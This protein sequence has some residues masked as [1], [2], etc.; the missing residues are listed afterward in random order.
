MSVG[1]VIITHGDTGRTLVEAGEFILGQSLDSIRTV[2]FRQ[3]GQHR[4]GDED[5]R[6]AAQAADQ[7][8]G[9]LVLTDLL[10]ASPCNRVT[11]VMKEYRA[12]AVTGLNLA[13]LIRVWNYRDE[14]L[15]TLASI[16]AEGGK[17]G[18]EIIGS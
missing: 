2:S 6:A 8:Q 17:R 9:V 10:G 12:M 5:I 13:M 18:V 16:A 4:T 15:P 14:P 7:G 11:R 3:S 1:L